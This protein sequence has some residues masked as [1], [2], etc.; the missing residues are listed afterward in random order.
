MLP[1]S[2]SLEPTAPTAAAAASQNCHLAVLVCRISL[3]DSLAPEAARELA[4]ELHDLTRT[5]VQQARRKPAQFTPPCTSTPHARSAVNVRSPR[6]C[7]PFI[8][9]RGLQV[10]GFVAETSMEGV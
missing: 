3:H 6:P 1:I 5:R 9:E 2:T 8:K 7:A 10:E 4:R